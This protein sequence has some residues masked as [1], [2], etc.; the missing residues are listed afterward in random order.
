MIGWLG[1]LYTKCTLILLKALVLVASVALGTLS[2]QAGHGA[3]PGH[4]PAVGHASGSAEGHGDEPAGRDAHPD[5]AEGPTAGAHGSPGHG[6]TAA[7]GRHDGG[8][9]GAAHGEGRDADHGG[10]L[11]PKVWGVPSGVWHAVNFAILFGA[12]FWLSRKGVVVAVKGRRDAIAKNIEEATKLREEMRA[13]FEDYDARMRNIDERM[14][15][16]VDD[17]KSEAEAEKK[18]M[19]SE[20][21]ALAARVRE[22]A[23]LV[24]EQ[25]I[26]RARR[27]L[28]DEQISQATT[29]AEQILKAN[30]TKEDQARLAE[31]FAERVGG[32]ARE[33]RA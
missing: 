11:G 12:I 31:E 20:A 22:D 17:A 7:A 15:A 6:G 27:E 23:K 10:V 32:K 30:V 3:E 5:A 1:V 25:E 8:S 33:G 16:I 4:A 24:A 2:A 29:L 28:Q 21:T 14:K 19:L 18:K 9:H 26:A 13:K